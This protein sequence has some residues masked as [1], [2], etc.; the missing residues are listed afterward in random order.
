MQKEG[1]QPQSI[2]T[3]GKQQ[4]FVVFFLTLFDVLCS[5]QLQNCVKAE[6]NK[7]I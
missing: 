6:I 2:V 1:C 3:S 7:M 4:K 5:K